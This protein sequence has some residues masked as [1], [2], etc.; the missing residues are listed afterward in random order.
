VASE[1]YVSIAV[2]DLAYAIRIIYF[3]T[4]NNKNNSSQR[5]TVLEIIYILVLSICLILINGCEWE[6][7]M[8]RPPARTMSSK[9]TIADIPLHIEAIGNCV[10]SELVSFVPQVGNQIIAGYFQQG[11]NVKVDAYL[12][13]ADEMLSITR[14]HRFN[15][16]TR[17]TVNQPPFSWLKQSKY[18]SNLSRIMENN[19]LF[20]LP[21][22]LR[23]F[24]KTPSLGS[25]RGFLAVNCR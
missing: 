13:K 23:N 10:T 16:P 9:M 14:G 20:R 18:A 2:I 22:S 19:F 25:D 5:M 11:Q 1:N 15:N 12:Y 24:Q 7:Q 6:T 21:E 8:A 3:G 17:G 4:K